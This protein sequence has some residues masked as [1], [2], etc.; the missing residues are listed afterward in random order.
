LKENG[1]FE[2]ENVAIAYRWADWQYD[3]L[4]ELAAEL[5]HRQV[6]V[7]VPQAVNNRRWRPRRQPRDPHRLQRC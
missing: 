2:G 7:I 6:T 3:R 4:P 5:V 1:Y